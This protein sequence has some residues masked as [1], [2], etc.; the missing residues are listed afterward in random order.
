MRRALLAVLASTVLLVAF[1]VLLGPG[2]LAARLAA[3]DPAWFGL[4]LA[5]VAGSLLCWSE[6]L[7]PLLADAGG[8]LTAWRTAVAY[9]ASMCGRQLVPV[10]AVGGPAITALAVEREGSLSYEE[11][12]AVVTVAE[13]LSTGASLALAAVGVVLVAGSGPVGVTVVGLAVALGG[14]AA[15]LAAVAVAAM[16]RRH[17]LERIVLWAIGLVRRGVARVSTRLATPLR[18]DRTAARLDRFFAT[19]DAVAARPRSLGL[20]YLYHQLG[21]LY[22]ALALSACALALEAPIGLGVVF[23][24]VPASLLVDVL[25]LPGGLGGIEFALAALLATLGGV[26]LAAAGAVVVLYRLCTYWFV[27]AV[28]GLAA[29]Y[30]AVSVRELVVE[31]PG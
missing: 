6:A 22:V 5:L 26:E 28:G 31:A 30:S 15:L 24:S 13:F 11:T 12:L 27:V 10:G 9:T 7:R 21:W 16:Y 1:V 3:T 23:L 25:P 8:P 18:P 19:I 29:V 17:P 20:S 4:A 14:V 2:A